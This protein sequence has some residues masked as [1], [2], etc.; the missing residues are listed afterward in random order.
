MTNRQGDGSVAQP[1][2]EHD[3]PKPCRTVMQLD[4]NFCLDTAGHAVWCWGAGQNND[5]RSALL[6]TDG[7]LCLQNSARQ[8]IAC[9]FQ[10]PPPGPGAY[11]QVRNDG[12]VALT[13]GRT[14]FWRVP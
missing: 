13:D 3:P 11:L 10:G 1:G 6:R 7:N 8:T 12:H 5:G 4:S 14:D 9:I 2:S